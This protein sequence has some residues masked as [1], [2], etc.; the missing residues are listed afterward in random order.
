VL[1]NPKIVQHHGTWILSS[2]CFYLTDLVLDP[3]SYFS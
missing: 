1:A 3:E 2:S